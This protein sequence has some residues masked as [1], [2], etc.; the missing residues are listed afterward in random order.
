MAEAPKHVQAAS[1]QLAFFRIFE[2]FFLDVSNHFS[3]GVA[4]LQRDEKPEFDV[5]VL[6]HESFIV[7]LS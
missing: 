4:S 1:L 2:S 3:R 6:S 5:S 7:M